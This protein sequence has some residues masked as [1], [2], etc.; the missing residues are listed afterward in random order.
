MV[1]LVEG[2]RVKRQK[3]QL[4]VAVKDGFIVQKGASSGQKVVT[5]GNEQLSDGKKVQIGKPS[6]DKTNRQKKP[7]GNQ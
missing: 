2:D 1:Y 5:R 3:I 6:F 7:K 4:G